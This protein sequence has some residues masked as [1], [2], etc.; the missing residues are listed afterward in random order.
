[1]KGTDLMSKWKTTIQL[2]DLHAQRRA[3][4]MTIQE[5]AKNLAARLRENRYSDELW[6]EIHEL[7]GDIENADHY[8]HILENLYNFGDYGQRIWFNHRAD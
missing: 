5:V 4:A 7:E 1:M 3:G 2:G 6:E 8:D